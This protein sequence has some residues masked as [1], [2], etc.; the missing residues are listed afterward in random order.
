MRTAGGGGPAP[1][2]RTT[3]GRAIYGG[4]V[5]LGCST[6]GGVAVVAGLALAAGPATATLARAVVRRAVPAKH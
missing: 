5:L 1:G 4:P 3:V 6:I 2:W